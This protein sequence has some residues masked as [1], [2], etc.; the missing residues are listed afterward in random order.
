MKFKE[1]PLSARISIPIILIVLVAFIVMTF[2]TSV[3]NFEAAKKNAEAH[4]LQSAKTY[5]NKLQSDLEG[6]YT[7]VK[8]LHALSLARLDDPT[9]TRTNV[10]MYY[11]KVLEDSK[12][13]F[14]VWALYDPNAFDGKDS[15]FLG[16][17]GYESTGAYG[18]YWTWGPDG[19]TLTWENDIDYEGEF[20]TVPKK[21]ARPIY[22]EPYYDEV[23]GENVFMTSVII[24]IYNSANSFIGS[25]G[26]D[27]TLSQLA[28]QVD[29]VKPYRSSRS[30][31]LSSSGKFVT[32]PEKNL[33]GKNFDEQFKNEQF[34]KLINSGK[35][36]SVVGKNN[37]DGEDYYL[38]VVPIS[39]AEGNDQW[40][41][42][43]E[44]PTS[45][46]LAEAKEL[47]FIQIL[48]SIIFS[49]LLSVAVYVFL[50]KVSNKFM[51]LTNRLS[52]AEDIVS[53]AIEQLSN[54]GTTLADSSSA[55]AASLEETVASLEE[56]TNMVKI[57]ASSADQASKLSFTSSES[58]KK[59]EE[60][61][62][63]LLKAMNEISDSSKKI[64]EITSVIDDLSFQTNLLALNASVEA[65][66]AGEQGKGFAVVADAV[67]TLAQKSAEAAKNISQLIAES[68]DRIDRGTQ[69][70][71]SAGSVLKEIVVSVQKVNDLNN[72]IAS[73][74]AE[75]SHGIAQINQAMNHL[76]HSIQGNAA[77]SEEIAATTL[78]IHG[79]VKIMQEAVKEMRAL[80]R[81]HE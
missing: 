13:L 32:H 11:K 53:G 10:D 57:S 47:L 73:S 43:I 58:A 4:L 61:M 16:K 67:R 65:A 17:P 20:Y 28:G 26:I 25:V 54:A 60:G 45:E 7:I 51:A 41:F 3:S 33:V 18:P 8:Q 29:T 22:M 14:G 64:E 49:A 72:E 21:L 66:R 77:S 76:D 31:L 6:K 34:K 9:L 42:I 44:T 19:K 79:Q 50:T 59:G 5:A 15:Y 40:K 35:A 56:I 36:G 38:T 62:D 30:F 70:A 74:S 27:I 63:A 23:G 48:V 39:L 1:L 37:E 71:S 81:G 80:V 75:Q 68:V 24:P 69:R 12:D 46:S 2:I 52:H 55:S 78:E